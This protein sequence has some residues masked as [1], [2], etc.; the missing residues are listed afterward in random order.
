MGNILPMID[1][2]INVGNLITILTIV[3]GGI[4]ALSNM[5]NSIISL[6]EDILHIEKRQDSLSEAFN[7]LGKILTQVA[8]QDSRLNMIEKNVDELRHGKGFIKHIHHK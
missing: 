3:G 4:F 1:W 6:R 2:T 5:Q 8:V 7:Q